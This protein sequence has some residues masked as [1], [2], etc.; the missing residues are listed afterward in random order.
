MPLSKLL[1]MIVVIFLLLP[2]Y[3]FASEPSPLKL[4]PEDRKDLL[5]IEDYLNEIKNLRAKFLQV[6]SNG[7][8]ATGRL[9]MARPGK[10]RF[11]YDPPSPI[12]LVSD[13]YFLRYIDK[14]LEQVTHIWLKNTPIGFLVEEK[15]KIKNGLTVTKFSRGAKK[16]SVSIAKP[17]KPE[18]GSITLV[19]SD[20]PL[21]L[22]KWIVTDAQGI[23]TTVALIKTERPKQINPAL[24][25]FNDPSQKK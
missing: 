10:I 24:F 5:R 18:Q 14:K 16:L 13:G 17:K 20:T 3:V 11:E 21:T 19:F 15:I 6:A 2:S 22:K 1:T 23:K 9:L 25:E 7:A 4:N 12:L 8:I